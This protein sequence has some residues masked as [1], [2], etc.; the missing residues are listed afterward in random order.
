MVSFRILSLFAAQLAGAISSKVYAPADGSTDGP[1][2]I[3]W[4]SVQVPSENYEPTMLSIQ[5]SSVQSLWGVIADPEANGCVSDLEAALDLAAS[6]GWSRSA[7]SAWLAGHEDNE[8]C[9]EKLLSNDDVA[10]AI[11]LG[12]LPSVDFDFPNSKPTFIL[13]AE[14]HGGAARPGRVATWWRRH[15][16]LVKEIGLNRA[17]REKPLVI[18]QKLNSSNFCPG[19]DVLDDLEAEVDEGRATRYIGMAVASFLD[20]IYHH[21][22]S[23]RLGELSQLTAI[24]MQPFLDA[25][26]MEHISTNG[27]DVNGSSPFCEKA[28]LLLS[29]LSSEDQTRLEVTDQFSPRLAYDFKT[30]EDPTGTLMHCHSN[31][32]DTGDDKL[33][34]KVCSYAGHDG[35]NSSGTEQYR[36]FDGAAAA[37]IG[38]KMT[39]SDF[40]AMRLGTTAENPN[41][42]CATINTYA[43]QVAEGMLSYE[44]FRRWHLH[45]RGIC[46]AADTQTPNNV[47]PLWIYGTT[48]YTETESCLQV[49]GFHLKLGV[50]E[51]HLP[52]VEYCKVM[53]PAFALDYMLTGSM[54][55][56]GS[57]TFLV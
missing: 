56:V 37:E 53:S 52:G 33:N 50:A 36:F 28:Q 48:N 21:E 10:G 9:A 27:L 25:L 6:K 22:A 24:L 14:L 12:A 7:G 40:L 17:L 31:V 13:S 8:T 4:P 18:L 55:P 1:I 47:G 32:T 29:G 15:V 42:S 23:E 57:R 20:G 41:T 3:L 34:V 38:C 19:Y 43:L 16:E 5:Q 44:Q 45:G 2:V 35:A 46:I 49:S 11:L 26:D 39:S 54:K 51:D 30:H